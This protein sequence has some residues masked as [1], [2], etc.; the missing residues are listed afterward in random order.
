M[1]QRAG[2]APYVARW[3]VPLL[4][5]LR[6]YNIYFFFFFVSKKYH[7][8]H[9]STKEGLTFFIFYVIM[10]LGI[11]PAGVTMPGW[12]NVLYNVSCVTGK[13]DNMKRSIYYS[14][15]MIGVTNHCLPSTD[16]LLYWSYTHIHTCDY[17]RWLLLQLSF[18]ADITRGCF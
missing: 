4:F 16:P 13:E 12:L 3:C 1:H 9:D 2:V 10:P 14:R 8:Y 15:V 7:F 6:G 11:K 18:E 5:R 17:G